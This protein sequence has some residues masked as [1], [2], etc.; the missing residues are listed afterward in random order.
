MSDFAL[1]LKDGSTLGIVGESG[2]GKSVAAR[3]MT[4]LLP[5]GLSLS[6]GRVFW[7]GVD[8]ATIPADKL[9]DSRGRVV[10]MVFQDA[11]A[12]M[13]PLYTIGEQITEGLRAHVQ[14]SARAHRQRVLDMLSR[15]G[16]ND[17]AVYYDRYPHQL[18]G[19]QMQRA[20]LAAALI[21]EPKI[22]IADEPTTGL[23]ATTQK[24]I[25]TLIKG[26]QREMGMTIIWISHDVDLV[27]QI[28]ESTIVMYAGEVVE[29]GRTEDLLGLQ[30]HP[31]TL[32]LL[33][34]RPDLSTARKS[35]L[36]AVPGNVP[37]PGAWPEA[38]RFAPR[39]E[40]ALEI[41]GRVHPDLHPETEGRMVRCHNPEGESAVKPD[42]QSQAVLS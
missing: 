39:C 38:C 33:K 10:G 11:R 42:R 31:Y 36:R 41:C 13:D 15:V 19:G 18:S 5:H 35:A 2:S 16:L 29:A 32:G 24:K 23:D 4:G 17:P 3:A 40:R 8:I 34:S 26:L 9:R 37:E 22:L 21:L 30:R 14:G 20:A 28:A 12:S 1:K 25:V 27:S 6:A 7:N